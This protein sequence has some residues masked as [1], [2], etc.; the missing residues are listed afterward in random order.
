VTVS[1]RLKSDHNCP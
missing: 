1:I